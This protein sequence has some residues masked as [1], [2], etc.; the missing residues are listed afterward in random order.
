MFY[1]IIFIIQC[2]QLIDKDGEVVLWLQVTFRL[3]EEVA[4]VAAILG[5]HWQCHRLGA[6]QENATELGDEKVALIVMSGH[7]W[8]VVFSSGLRCS[9][10][11]R[12]S[13]RGSSGGHKRD[14]E[15]GV[16]GWSAAALWEGLNCGDKNQGWRDA[17]D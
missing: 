3:L 4:P 10:K 11:T 2:S 6:G 12:S 16:C 13:W 14:G 15:S 17:V 8:S 5:G 1:F 9:R 7:I